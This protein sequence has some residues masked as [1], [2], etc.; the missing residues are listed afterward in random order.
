M[1]IVNGDVPAFLESKKV[2]SLEWRA[3]RNA[4]L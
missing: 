1:R 2:V 4:S 3:R